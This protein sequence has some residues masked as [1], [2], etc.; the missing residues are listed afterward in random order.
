MISGEINEATCNWLGRCAPRATATEMDPGPTVMGNA[1]TLV[2][3]LIPPLWIYLTLG[4]GAVL[5]LLL[6]GLGAFAY[7]T[8]YLH[9]SNTAIRL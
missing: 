1:A 9:H 3:S 2:A 7:R 6:F 4:V 8:L 5:Y